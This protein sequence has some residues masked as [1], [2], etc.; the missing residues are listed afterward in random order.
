[1]HVS[2]PVNDDNNRNMFKILNGDTQKER[3]V[4]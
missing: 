2:F 3:K 4:S 1:M